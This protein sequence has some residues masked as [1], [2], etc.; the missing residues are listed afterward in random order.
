MTVHNLPVEPNRFIGRTRDVAELSAL[1]R[2]ER[3]ITLSG[4]GG[5]GKTRLSLRVAAG[6]LMALSA[7]AQAQDD[8][9]GAVLAGSAATAL[10]E[11]IGRFGTPGRVQELLGLARD[12]LGEGRVTTV[13]RHVANIMGKLGFDARSQIAVWAADH[14]VDAGRT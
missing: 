8:L 4:V 11:S 5:I 6:A 1:V 2:E 9:E 7:L 3:V 12:R 14:E 13:A 10:R